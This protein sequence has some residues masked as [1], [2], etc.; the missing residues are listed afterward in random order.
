[1]AEPI[2]DRIAARDLVTRHHNGA[3]DDVSLKV[4]LSRLSNDASQLAHDELELVK[5]EVRDIAGALSSDVR[6]AGQTLA[7]DLA[8]VGVA[9]S[10]ALMAG[11]ALT[12]GA[13]I[14][15]GELLGDAYWAGGLIVGVILMIAAAMSLKSAASDAKDNDALRLETT[16]RA[17]REDR[18][19]LSEEARE[20][21]QFAK[22]EAREFKE[23]ARPG[24][25]HVHHH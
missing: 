10:L 7:K 1:M 2:H 19:V 17:I 21:A 9:L 12:A 24:T 16:R 8:K 18:E 23:H 25:D 14:G 5:M 4:L 13:V 11:L 15:I 6:E 22:R 3:D 20:T